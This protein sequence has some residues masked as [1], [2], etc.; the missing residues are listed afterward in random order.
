[1]INYIILNGVNSNT[2]NGLLISKL[3][4]ITKPPLKTRVDD[5]EGRDGDIVTPIGYGAYDK[6]MEIGLYGDYDID[7][8]IKYFDSEGTVTFSNEDDKYYRYQIIEKI[9]FEKLIRFK[10]ATVTMHVQPFKYS[11]VDKEK[12]FLV[13]NQLLNFTDYTQT[14][15]GITVTVANGVVLV[16]GTG[17]AATEFYIPI[18]AVTLPAANYALEAYASGAGASACSFRLIYNSPSAANSFGGTYATLQNENTV[19]I[20]ANLTW[21]QTYNYIYF[22]ISAGVELNFSI[23]FF[24]ENTDEDD[25]FIRN[26]GN[27]VSKPTMTIYG[28][29]TINLGLN[30]HQVF[31]IELGSEGNITINAEQ[32]EAYKDGMLK[33]RLVTGNYDNLALNIGKN[34]ISTVG[35]V[36]KIEIENYSR[37]I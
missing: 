4:P 34:T 24:L 2:I 32:M 7:E 8:V 17:S 36:S 21:A 9:D 25:I 16:S 20:S 22:Y 15:N 37:W 35:E 19:K 14:T 31:K 12:T 5:I 27:I 11:L 3:P 10:T 26:N 6:T 18:P 28:T 30:G 1:M 29:G 33:N 23:D 13:H